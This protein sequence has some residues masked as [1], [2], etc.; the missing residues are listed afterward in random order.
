MVEVDVAQLLQGWVFLADSVQGS[1]EQVQVRFLGEV[2][3]TVLVLLRI[4]VFLPPLG[5]RSVLE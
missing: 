5:Q 2:A 4:Q 1:Q 3:W